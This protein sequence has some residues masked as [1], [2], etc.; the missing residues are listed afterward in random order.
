MSFWPALAAVLGLAALLPAHERALRIGAVLYALLLVAAF[1]VDSPLGGN[2]T[3][4]GALA[5]GPVLLGA[6]VGRRSP[7]LL[8]ALAL[9]LAYWPLHASI[10]D[11]VRATGDPSVH[12]A[13]Y[14]P[15]LE[16][17][18]SRPRGAGFRVE[19]PMT[20]N[21]WEARHVPGGR[22][23][24]PLARG[25]ERQLDR[26]YGALFYDARLDAATYRA[27]LER[28]AVAYVAVPDVALDDAGRD[29][30]RLVT[31]GLPY[32]REAWHDAHWRVFAVR[33][34]A[35]LAAARPGTAASATLSATGMTIRASRAGPV[36][37][38]VRFTRWWRVS[39]GRGCVS[40]APGGMT[41][42]SFDGPGTISLQARL[43][44]SAC[45]R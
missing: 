32:L 15:L 21:H 42:V 4:L 45:R 29:E 39:G 43:S 25:W 31:A 20:A 7:V 14:A 40:E 41:R 17:L 9:P 2:A 36:R 5:A 23:G 28:H 12:A 6:L 24:F 38:A 30:A 33:R 13:Y 19:I 22:D 1:V 8:A 27:W 34:P 35:P 16:F 37:V 18:H 11:V 3:R 26:R 10:R 44:G